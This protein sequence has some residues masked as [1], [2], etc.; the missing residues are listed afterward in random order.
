M[1]PEILGQ[2]AA[3]KGIDLVATGDW[4][5]PL[6]LKELESKLEEAEK[7]IFRLKGLADFSSRLN[8]RMNAV[9][10]NQKLQNS[11]PQFILSTEISSIYSQG[12]KTRKIHNLI[13]APSFETVRQINQ[14]LKAASCNLMSDGRPI[15]GLS[16]VQLAELVWGIDK[17]CLIIPA[18]CWTPWF[19]MFGS[20]SGFDSIKECWGKYAEKIYAVETGLSSD[21]AMNWRIKELDSRTIVS[22]SDAHSP[23]RLGREATVFELEDLS[24]TNISEAL[25]SRGKQLNHFHPE[26]DCSLGRASQPL[27]N[28]ILYTIEFY[29]QEGKYHYT[30]HRKCGVCHSPAETKSKGE[31]CPVCGKPLTLGVMHRVE[32][33]A[34]RPEAKPLLKINGQGLAG[35]YCQRDPQ[36]PPYIML[37][38]L[39][40]IISE[41]LGFGKTSKKVENEYNNLTEQ[42]GSELEI[43]TQI[44]TED[45]RR[46][47]GEKIAGGVAKVRKG[48]IKIEP[49][50]DGVF[51]NVTIWKENPAKINQQTKQETL[52]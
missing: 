44:K 10:P 20:K 11:P 34:G 7:G 42:L 26:S 39:V 15:I 24:F 28:R 4:T 13:L 23:S 48:E 5:H 31:I 2:W 33:L 12:G 27:S 47:A 1:E 22:F 6:W 45:I 40:E 50:F 19:A 8:R 17:D 32:K 29:P 16:S 21:P 3:R 14:A 18:H 36:R 25:K 46:L 43:L 41:C 9:I 52:F 35:Y 38:P 51:G 30:G 37:V 49:G